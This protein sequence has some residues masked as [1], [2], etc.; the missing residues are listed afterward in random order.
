MDTKDWLDDKKLNNSN[1]SEW[2]RK[3]L[4]DGSLYSHLKKHGQHYEISRTFYLN[5]N[6]TSLWPSQALQVLKTVSADLGVKVTNSQIKSSMWDFS[7]SLII[8][9]PQTGKESWKK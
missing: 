7:G 9:D 6:S 3:N 8:V 2:T 1:L 5:Q 4:P